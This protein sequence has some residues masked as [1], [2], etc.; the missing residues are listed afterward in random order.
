MFAGF[1][2]PLFTWFR[3]MLA[4]GCV[5]K[6]AERASVPNCANGISSQVRPL[7]RHFYINRTSDIK[8]L[9]LIFYIEKSFPRSM[10]LWNPLSKS[11]YISPLP[12]FVLRADS[13]SS[14]TRLALIFSIVLCLS[15]GE[16]DL[17]KFKRF[18]TGCWAGCAEIRPGLG[19]L[20]KFQIF[21]PNF[22]E[23]CNL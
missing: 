2:I 10:Y 9:A 14:L 23:I 6:L 3:A 11:G 18:L 22:P 4:V 20:H 13:Y 16:E 1:T 21:W 19:L 7:Y 8:S 12:N 17:T 5:T 15:L